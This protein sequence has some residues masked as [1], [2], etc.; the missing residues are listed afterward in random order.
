[1]IDETGEKKREDFDMVEM[2]QSLKKKGKK[3]ATKEDDF[4]ID[5]NDNR[6]EA[7]VKNDDF[8]IDVTNPA[9]VKTKQMEKLVN[10]VTKRR[11]KE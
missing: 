5:L 6:F 11:R 7:L 9:F 2:K 4:E 10:E 3:R 8:G 1:M